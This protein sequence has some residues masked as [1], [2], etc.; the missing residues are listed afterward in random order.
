VRYF[1]SIRAQCFFRR[2]AKLETAVSVKESSIAFF[3]G[4]GGAAASGQACTA[5]AAIPAPIA[6]IKVVAVR[7]LVVGFLRRVTGPPSG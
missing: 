3:V 7:K 1:S 6:Y 5:A 4:H 2:R